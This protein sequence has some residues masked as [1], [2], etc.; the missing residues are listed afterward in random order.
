[1]FQAFL[2]NILECLL[3]FY[4]GLASF[5]SFHAN[6]QFFEPI[7]NPIYGD[8]VHEYAAITALNDTG[9]I[10][11][12]GGTSATQKGN[13]RVFKRIS[14]VWTQIGQKIFNSRIGNRVAING[15]GYRIAI[16]IIGQRLSGQKGM[17]KVYDYINGQWTQV[18]QNILGETTED[19]FGICLA[20]NRN[21]DRLVVG[22]PRN[23]G[24]GLNAG[25]VRVYEERNGSW[26]QLGSDIDGGPLESFGLDVDIDDSGNRISSVA[27]DY[28]SQN[29]SRH[30]GQTRIF[31]FQNGSWVQVGQGLNG[32]HRS[33]GTVVTT[34]ISGNGDVVLYGY[35]HGSSGS[36]YPF[37]WIHG[38]MQAFE[39]NGNQ[40]QTIG[41]T[42]W[43]DTLGKSVGAYDVDMS[44]D[45]ST[46]IGGGV[47][48][49]AVGSLRSVIRVFRM[50]NTQWVQYGPDFVGLPPSEDQYWVS[51][52]RDGS[53]VA[54]S[55]GA[56]LG[57]YR[58]Y[59]R[60]RLYNVCD[61]TA[62]NKFDTACISYTSPSGRYQWTTSGT[63]R[64]TVFAIPGC[65]TIYNIHLVIDNSIR[66]NRSATSCDFYNSPSGNHIWTQSGIHYDT[67]FSQNGCD[68]IFRFDLEIYSS[69]NS[70]IVE[71]ACNKYFS[72]SGKEFISSGSYIDTIPNQQG[73]D[74]VIQIDLNIWQT[75][76]DTVSTEICKYFLLPTGD[77][78]RQSGTYVDSLQSMNSC[79]SIIVYDLQINY[80]VLD[81]LDILN[82]DYQYTS[83]SGTYTWHE[84]GLYQDTLR[85]TKACD[86][87][88]TIELDFSSKDIEIEKND[89][90][91]T[92][93]SPGQ[94]YQWIYCDSV[95][96]KGE[97]NKLFIAPEN[98]A[99]AVI[100]YNG[101]CSDTSGCVSVNSYRGGSSSPSYFTRFY[102][103]PS[104]SHVK[105]VTNR[106]IESIK[107]WKMSGQ[108]V[109]DLGADLIID[110]NELSN[111]EYIMGLT[112]IN[113]A[114]VYLKF[115]K[116]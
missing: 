95:K 16:G 65:D 83:P 56:N 38:H 67:T 28:Y 98:G 26:V 48:D 97:T 82:C 94:S 4:L 58:T 42:I 99:Y 20:L 92:V 50:Y 116:E 100:V 84:P 86:T 11:V 49:T 45:G 18:G 53:V 39:L 112:D 87:V 31:E 1:M 21:G 19:H 12:I 5:S 6:A 17:V 13:V 22:A 47:S 109:R 102:P 78:L 93:L 81:T 25:H 63:Y 7:G 3:L 105:V 32:P 69:S 55:A 106:T 91:L 9:N 107:I 113:G 80:Y 96:F 66:V 59:G 89:S 52:N 110:I 90:L 111:G 57:Q 46:I 73:C 85:S 74:S 72:P 14:G 104:R 79:D 71:T 101:L 33:N 115:I 43:S 37:Y 70:T 15:S 8:S 64:D 24:N 29:P 88:Y 23:S 103:N 36:A 41:D 10:V 44:R 34:S 62:V 114:E 40:W 77:T 75:T 35:Y 51:T 30:V 54:I 76:Y 68:S 60:V 108:L 2:K 61:T 27:R